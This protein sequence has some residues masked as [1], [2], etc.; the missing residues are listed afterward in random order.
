MEG[1]EHKVS[2]WGDKLHV[3]LDLVIVSQLCGYHQTV[4]MCSVNGS[5]A[6]YVNYLSITLLLKK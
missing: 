4:E 3:K 5:N 1:N 6:G 2:Y